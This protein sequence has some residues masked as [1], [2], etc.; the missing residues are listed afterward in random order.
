MSLQIKPKNI[1]EARKTA[2]A[3]ISAENDIYFMVDTR[4]TYQTQQFLNQF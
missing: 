1:I 2:I 3:D 4:S